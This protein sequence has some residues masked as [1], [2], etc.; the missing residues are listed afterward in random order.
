M[1]QSKDVGSLSIAQ[2]ELLRIVA[3]FQKG[4]IPSNTLWDFLPH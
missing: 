4:I 1:S 2:C 3:A